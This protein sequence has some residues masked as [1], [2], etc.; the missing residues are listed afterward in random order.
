MT[1]H[2]TRSG[3]SQMYPAMVTSPIGNIKAKGY[4]FVVDRVETVW[5]FETRVRSRSLFICLSAPS[6]SS[7]Y[8]PELTCSSIS[9]RY[10]GVIVIEGSQENVDEFVYRIKQLQWKALQVRCEEDGAVVTPPKEVPVTEAREWV[11]RNRSHLGPVLSQDSHDKICV[12][13]VEGLNDLGD[14]YVSCFTLSCQ[15][16]VLTLSQWFHRMRKA[17]LE[18]VFLTALKISK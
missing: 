3:Y 1:A 11:V 4:S 16:L 2:R 9:L 15:L 7:E 8:V 5:N 14:M 10:P 17:G 12:R 6:K 18:E 13:E